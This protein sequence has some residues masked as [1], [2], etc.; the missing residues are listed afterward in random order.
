MKKLFTTSLSAFLFVLAMFS[1]LV[2]PTQSRA[3]DGWT[4]QRGSGYYNWVSIAPSSDGSRAVALSYNGYIYTTSDSGITWTQRTSDAGR[5]WYSVT[6]SASGQYLAAVVYGGNIW[7]SSNYGVTWTVVANTANA[8][9][10]SWYSIDS[11]SDGRYLSAVVKNGNIWTSTDFGATWT[12]VN[13]AGAKSW[14]AITSSSNGQNLA[15]IVRGGN[16]WT[17]TNYGINWTER[18]I[19]GSASTYF[20][21]ISSSALGDKLV[22]TD[23]NQAGY[24]YISNDYGLTWTPKFNIPSAGPANQWYT[25]TYSDDGT[26]IIASM[27][28]SYIYEST[29]SGNTWSAVSG[30]GVRS[31]QPVVYSSDGTKIFSSVGNGYIYTYGT[32]TTSPVITSTSASAGTSTITLKGQTSTQSTARNFNYGLTSSYGNTLGSSQSGVLNLETFSVSL[33]SVL[34]NTI[35]HYNVTAT[36][37]FGSNSSTDT[38][39]NILPFTQKAA[40][41]ARTWK[42]ITVSSD[43]RYMAAVVN[44]GYI[45]TSNDYGSTWTQKTSDATRAWAGITS[46][47][48]GQYLVAVVNGGYIYASNDYGDTWT[49]KTSDATRAWKSVTSSANGQYLAAVVT[50]GYIYTSNDYGTTWTV[51][52]NDATRTWQ[53]VSSSALGDKMMAIKSST[54]YVYTSTDYGVTWSEIVGN[55]LSS[56]LTADVITISGD[57]TKAVVGD[58]SGS[59]YTSSDNG[60]NW[61]EHTN[62]G[63]RLWQSIVTSA[64]GSKIMAVNNGGYLYNSLDGGSSWVEQTSAGTSTWQSI[65]A[66]A[67]GSV[68]AVVASP[69]YVY[70]Y[71]PS[72]STIST[73]SS[74]EISANSATLAGSILNTGGVNDTVRGFEYGLDTSY[75]STT[76]ESGSFSISSYSLGA[77]LLS[78]GTTY[79]YRAY[80]TNNSGTGYGSDLTFATIACPNIVT[81]SYSG[82]TLSKA[83]L[84]SVILETGGVNF[85]TRGFEYGIDTSYGQAVNEAGSFSTGSY[86]L[87]I[88][89]LQCSKIYHYRAYAINTLGTV[90]GG[91]ASFTTGTCPQAPF[92]LPSGIGGGASDESISMNATRDINQISTNGVNVLAYIDSQANFKTPK[93]SVNWQLG[94]YS[95]QISDLN[96]ASN[97][98][99][100]KLDSQDI[101]LKKGESKEVNLDGD[102]I[103]DLKLTFANVYVNRAEITIKSLKGEVVVAP[104]V[105]QPQPVVTQVITPTTEVKKNFIFNKDLKLDQINSDVKELQKFLNN[106]GYLIANSGVGSKGLETTKFGS[107]TKAALI[108]FQK[109]NKINPASGVFGPMTRKIVNGIK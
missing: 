28:D 68:I 73:V 95:L 20:F 49:Q 54:N 60:V 34:A 27:W 107:A 74:T 65:A 25:A 36:N 94:N 66:S 105:T 48:N 8:A 47:A 88:I 100:L 11:S 29:D 78:C 53:S 19:A 71:R 55:G 46:S 10:R 40:D 70:V 79:H 31:W 98:I 14:R 57:G 59:V 99:T 22:I 81:D 23:H 67:D 87:N 109:A 41:S 92:V 16:V 106:H 101:V 51:R 37:S 4:E 24:I 50:G 96:L 91:D 56:G 63:V 18:V 58:D 64:D 1:F 77:S 86:S 3:A 69:G 5:V 2:L 35:Y 93:S 97:I 17:S 13:N 6:S 21:S 42:S 84:S 30:A 72:I 89:N 80:A 33:P 102:K 43:G 62:A 9:N 38:S 76:S 15:A 52:K 45:Y 12:N 44:G 83:T 39:F 108:K 85:T 32:I 82:V 104:V 61:T 26:K 103:N 90:V 7:T 75:G